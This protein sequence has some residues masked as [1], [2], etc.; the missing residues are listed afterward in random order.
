MSS[1]TT[2]DTGAPRLSGADGVRAVAAL[3]V[4]LYHLFQR[5]SLPDQAPWLQDLQL[6]IMKGS[7]GVS[8][9]FVLSGMLL[10][11]P[12]WRAYLTGRTYPRL[13][14]YVRR[15]V[16]RIVPGFYA[17]LALSFVVGLVLFP[18]AGY[19]VVRLISGFTFTSGFHWVTFFPSEA[20]GPLW[21]I[22][23]EVISY[24]LMPLAMWGLFAL[25]RRGGIALGYWAG[26]FGLVIAVNQWIVTT[27]VPSEVGRGWQYGNLGG[28]K[29]W[30]PSYNPVGF[31]GHFALGIVAAALI[32]VWQVRRHGERR[33][34]FDA[35]AAAATS[36]AV[37]LVWFFRDP[38]EPLYRPNFQGQPYLFPAFAGLVALALVG[39]AHSRLLGRLADNPFAR[40]TAKVSFG[41]YIWHYLVLHLFSRMT[42]GEFE[43]F[44]ITDPWRHLALSLGVL[45]VTYAVASASW[46][47]LER[48]ALRSRWAN[49]ATPRPSDREPAQPDDAARAPAD[50]GTAVDGVPHLA[51]AGP[52]DAAAVPASAR[53]VSAAD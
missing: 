27:F 5:L 40:Y 45:A 49:R 7:F 46:F 23:F 47:W 30:M 3:W 48:P 12:F 51:D 25:R 14:H 35:L 42:D 39:L 33:W 10:S 50:A 37:A 17:S 11:L 4:V 15:R 18:D 21:S 20:N 36:G 31:F 1:T 53:S 22:G 38:P 29:E 16:A 41:I 44:G 52:A 19:Q 9:F 43:Y 13:G 28:A 24:V 26:V 34:G 2:A 6:V 32:A 8:I